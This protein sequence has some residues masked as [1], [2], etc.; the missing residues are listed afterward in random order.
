MLQLPIFIFLLFPMVCALSFHFDRAVLKKVVA[1]LCIGYTLTCQP[2][3]SLAEEVK[4]VK[5]IIVN[6]DG[7]KVSLGNYLGKKATLIVNINS[8]CDL[9]AD[10]EPQCK[11]LADLYKR[12]TND[13]FQ[14]LA[15]PSDQFRDRSM[16]GES[17]P[18]EDV[19]T[20]LREQYDMV[21]PIFDFVEVNG[22][23]AAEIFKVMKDIKSINPSDLKKINWNFE[24]FLLN[25][26]GVPVR[27]YRSTTLPTA[28]QDD[29][30]YLLKTG[31]LKPRVKASLGV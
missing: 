12:F 24:K 2:L 23:N 15:F 1:N 26:D 8:Q 6:Y 30:E 5:N 25:D 14:I 4:S 29:V 13:G 19:R 9:P 27:R 22:G 31:T 10:G 7:E 18:I 21:F 28:I 11:P 16:L 17:D 3:T 20:N